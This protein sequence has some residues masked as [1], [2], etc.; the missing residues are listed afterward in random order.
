MRWKFVFPGDDL[1][2]SEMS[3]P[4]PCSD[5]DILQVLIIFAIARKTD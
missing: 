1:S 3:S 2:A 5:E 4:V